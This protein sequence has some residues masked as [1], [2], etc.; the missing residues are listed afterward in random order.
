MNNT[1]CTRP[2]VTANDDP[3]L[4]AFVCGEKD[5]TYTEAKKKKKTESNQEN[6]KQR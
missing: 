6:K 1:D 4:Y 5:R 3:P 2:S